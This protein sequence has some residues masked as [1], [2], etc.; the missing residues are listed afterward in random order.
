LRRP[1]REVEEV[2]ANDF[3]MLNALDYHL[4]IYDLR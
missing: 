2:S 1:A 4:N 3:F